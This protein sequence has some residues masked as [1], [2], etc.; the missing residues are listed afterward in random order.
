MKYLKIIS[1]ILES[2]MKRDNRNR[3]LIK[4]NKSLYPFGLI[5][6]KNNFMM[7]NDHEQSLKRHQSRNLLR[8]I[9]IPMMY[10]TT[11]RDQ[12]LH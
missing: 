5:L 3:I 9:S 7:H 2:S 8:S 6:I 1:V 10:L 11:H 4:T 12:I